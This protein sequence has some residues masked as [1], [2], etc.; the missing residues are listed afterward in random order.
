MKVAVGIHILADMYGIEPE[1]LERKE[2]LMEIIERSIRVGNLTKIS[3]DY[4]QFE[5]VG[6]SGIV[7]LAESHISFHTW[8]EYGMIA[9][10]L[11]TC[12]DPEKADIAFQYIKEKLN[13]KEV[14]FVKHE[15]GSK[16]SLSNAP[17]PAA[18]QFV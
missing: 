7:L 8:P 5:P 12:G 14:Q 17:Q 4:Y 3:S 13:P 15:R 18:T 11:F 16:V 2:N 10:D 9:L 1:L 6:A